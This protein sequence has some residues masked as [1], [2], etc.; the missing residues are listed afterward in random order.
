MW[1][2]AYNPTFWQKDKYA[3]VDINLTNREMINFKW[4]DFSFARI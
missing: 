2:I 1:A 4:K 3:D